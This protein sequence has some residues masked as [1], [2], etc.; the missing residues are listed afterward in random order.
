[1]LLSI[2]I[3]AVIL[4]IVS[5]ININQTTSYFDIHFSKLPKTWKIAEFKFKKIKKK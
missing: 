3:M 4:Y 5:G 2:L 1:M